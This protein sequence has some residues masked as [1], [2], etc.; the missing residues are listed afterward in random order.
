MD[1][2]KLVG[3]KINA[4]YARIS[5]L[6]FTGILR[7]KGDG[8]LNPG[9]ESND[10]GIQDDSV[11]I[12]EQTQD[13]A[14]NNHEESFNTTQVQGDSNRQSSNLPHAGIAALTRSRSPSSSLPASPLALQPAHTAQFTHQASQQ[15]QQAFLDPS[16]SQEV[17]Q[18]SIDPQPFDLCRPFFDPTMLDLFPSGEMPDLSQFDMSLRNLDYFQLNDWNL[19]SN[20]PNNQ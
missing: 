2:K 6:G 9:E 3:F 7:S 19:T 4:A 16:T 1:I 5:I 15:E 12:P 10:L 18:F 11:Q 13:H 20:N 8:Y 17:N 14:S